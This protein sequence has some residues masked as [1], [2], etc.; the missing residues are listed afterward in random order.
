MAGYGTATLETDGGRVIAGGDWTLDQIGALS[1]RVA[2]VRREMA[3]ASTLDARALARV[4]TA[5]ASLLL[6]LVDGDATRIDAP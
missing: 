6:D 3:A 4:D 1:A 2:R 5:G